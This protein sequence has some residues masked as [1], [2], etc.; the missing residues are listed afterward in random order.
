M[1]EQTTDTPRYAEPSAPVYQ[2]SMPL[3]SDERAPSGNLGRLEDIAEQI[4]LELRRRNDAGSDFS[5]S[6][7]MAGITM[8]ISLALLAYAY[9]YRDNP[10]SLQSLLLLGLML[11]SIT[12]SLLIM[13]RQK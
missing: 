4:L 13:G 12:I 5:V 6:K 7:L 11:Q 10:T 9:L 2:Q 1:V 3:G 8:V